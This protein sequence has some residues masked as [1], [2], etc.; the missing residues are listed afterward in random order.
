MTEAILLSM[1]AATHAGCADHWQV[2]I[3]AESFASNGAGRTF[4]AG[5]L[6]SFRKRLE[7]ELRSAMNN[8][9][10]I[11]EVPAATAK[12][13]RTVEAFSA[14]GATEP[15]LYARGG[16]RLAIEWVFA[17]QGLAI[18]P[19]AD[20]VAGTACWIDPEGEACA[21]EGD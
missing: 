15:R 10:A 11:G 4:N 13:V 1:A 9:C 12:T 21:S 20:I 2:R 7:A 17:E 14:S 6:A 19:G 16:D 3:N 8:A 18:P 5:E